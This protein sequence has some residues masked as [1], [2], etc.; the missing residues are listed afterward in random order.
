[1][2]L[3]TDWLMFGI[4]AVYVIATIFICVANI[5]AAK[6]SREQIAESQRQFNE[7]RRLDVMPYLQFE[8]TM[9]PGVDYQLNL[10][11]SEDD[12]NTGECYCNLRIKN[13][14]R[15][16][17]KDIE[18]VWINFSKTYGQKAFPVRAMQNGDEYYLLICFACPQTLKGV[19]VASINLQFKD[20]LENEYTQRIDFEFEIKNSS[21]HINNHKTH[22]ISRIQGSRSNERM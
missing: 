9:K 16:T 10:V 13:I 2:P 17:A 12:Y 18:Y 20:L 11:L 19:T 15:G 21:V 5:K 8:K 22:P 7:N 14:G 1:M 6:A 3:I 4:T